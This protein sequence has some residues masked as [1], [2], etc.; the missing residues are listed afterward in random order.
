MAKDSDIRNTL[1]GIGIRSEAKGER[2]KAKGERRKEEESE[3]VR[4]E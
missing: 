3:K 4:N 1:P 2:R